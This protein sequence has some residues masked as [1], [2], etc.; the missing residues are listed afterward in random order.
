[1]DRLDA[2][3]LEEVRGERGPCGVRGRGTEGRDEHPRPSAGRRQMCVRAGP[4]LL[5]RLVPADHRKT[6]PGFCGR[7][8]LALHRTLGELRELTDAGDGFLAPRQVLLAR[9]PGRRE[10][11]R[12][13]SGLQRCRLP[14][15]PLDLLEEGPGGFRELVGEPLH[16]PGAARRVDHPGQMRLLHQ[17]R[18]GVTGDAPRERVRQAQR[19]IERQHGHRFG[20]ADARAETGQRGAEHVHPRIAPGHHHRR[21]HCVLP[22]RP[23]PGGAADLGDPRPQSARG[24]HLGD[25]Q[26]LVG[27]GRVPE[28]QLRAGLFDAEARLGQR[29]QVGDPRGQ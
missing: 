27:G 9:R 12:D 11:F 26:K 18:R 19:V 21:R 17:D 23:G 28:L 5:E 20:P 2:A 6:A 13:Q 3:R 10:P 22:L 16:V 24:P 7:R 1:M 14:A 4:Q 25:R 8:G 29:P 15:R